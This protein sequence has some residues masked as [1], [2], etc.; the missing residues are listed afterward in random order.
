[1]I[2]VMHNLYWTAK[3]HSDWKFFSFWY[4]MLYGEQTYRGIPKSLPSKDIE[5]KIHIIHLALIF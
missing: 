5:C 4:F 1:M 2:F 3:Q